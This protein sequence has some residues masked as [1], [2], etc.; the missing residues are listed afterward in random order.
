MRR[1]HSGVSEDKLEWSEM[2]RRERSESVGSKWTPVAR[3]GITLDETCSLKRCVCET[4]TV[5]C[6]E[7]SAVEGCA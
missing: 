5:R 4:R 6:V 1:A 2:R 7:G 3:W